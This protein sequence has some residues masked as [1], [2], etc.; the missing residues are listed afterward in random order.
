[1]KRAYRRAQGNVGD[2]AACLL[3]AIHGRGWQRKVGPEGMAGGL[4]LAQVLEKV[5]RL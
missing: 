3:A 1:M 5:K 2:A 4:L